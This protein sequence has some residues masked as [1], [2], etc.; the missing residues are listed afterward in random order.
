MATKSKSYDELISL[1]TFEERYEYLKT[2]NVVGEETFGSSRF[3]NQQFYKSKEWKKVRRDIIIRDNGCDLGCNDRE[4]HGKI[5]VHHI[6]PI[7]SDDI[8]NRDPCL[9]DSNNLICVSKLTHDAI[10][11]GDSDLLITVPTE[12]SANDTCPWKK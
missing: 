4:I 3:L 7:T 12:R 10:H 6:N 5:Y 11:Y 1:K 9:F 8:L 2:G